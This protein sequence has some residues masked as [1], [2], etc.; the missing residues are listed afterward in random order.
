MASST[1]TINP[2]QMT[3]VYNRLLAI[4]TELQTNAVPAIKEIMDV[5]FY[6]EGK[7]IDAIAAYPEANEKF[8]EL[9]EHYNRISTLVNDTLTQMM[10]TDEYAAIRIIAALEV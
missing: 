9:V 8:L 10:Q 3:D 4:A 1:I 7:A 2:E 5:E 6:T